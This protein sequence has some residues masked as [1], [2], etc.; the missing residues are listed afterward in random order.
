MSLQSDLV[1]EIP[2]RAWLGRNDTREMFLRAGAGHVERSED[3]F[4]VMSS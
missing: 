4:F 2:P 1:T 3:A